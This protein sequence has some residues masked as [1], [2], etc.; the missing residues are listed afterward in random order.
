ME[1]LKIFTIQT[2]N[3]EE[4]YFASQPKNKIEQN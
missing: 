3:M 1:H 4:L 2:A